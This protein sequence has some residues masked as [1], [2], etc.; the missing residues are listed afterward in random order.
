MHIFTMKAYACYVKTLIV[1]EKLTELLENLGLTTE[2]RMH[3][4]DGLRL[5]ERVST[6]FRI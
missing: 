6:N 2:D 1:W 5:H 4:I 3:K